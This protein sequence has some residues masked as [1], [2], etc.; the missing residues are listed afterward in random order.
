MLISRPTGFM[1]K[2]YHTI[3]TRPLLRHLDIRRTLK[4]EKTSSNITA[5]LMRTFCF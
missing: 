2:C 1:I 4:L 3:S 5:A